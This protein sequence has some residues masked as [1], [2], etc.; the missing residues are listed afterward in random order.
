MMKFFRRQLFVLCAMVA[1][2][3]LS[4]C[5]A[6]IVAGAAGG[7][8][9]ANDERTTGSLVEDEFIEI[10]ARARFSEQIGGVAHVGITSYNRRVL[11][12]GQVPSAEVRQQI[13]DLIEDIEHV[14]AVID[15][16]QIG[17]PSS[18]TSRAADAALTARVKIEL[19]NIQQE[20]FSCL[21][22]KIVSEQ[23][24]LYLLG[25]VSKE[26]AAIAIQAVRTVPG[27]IKVV[28]VFEFPQL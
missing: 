28:R 25:L 4:G 23:G 5:P 17:N 14:R 26:Q 10:K 22:I 18:L 2:L 9:V 7:S 6:A 21:D 27:V 3:L 8:L 12:T 24:V 13:V 11:L 20:D 16:M 19:C 15:Q 1:P